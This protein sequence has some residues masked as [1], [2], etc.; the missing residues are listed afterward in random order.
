M[1]MVIWWGGSVLVSAIAGWAGGFFASD[2]IKSMA[3]FALVAAVVLGFIYLRG[4][5]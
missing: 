4:W 3:W 1:P 5:L 2:S